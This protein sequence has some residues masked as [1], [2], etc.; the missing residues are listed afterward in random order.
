MVHDDDFYNENVLIDFSSQ[1]GSVYQP[2]ITQSKTLLP[3]SRFLAPYI[4]DNI[5]EKSSKLPTKSAIKRRLKDEPIKVVIVASSLSSKQIELITKLWD[6]IP[7]E[8]QHLNIDNYFPKESLKEEVKLGCD[9]AATLRGG[10]LIYGNPALVIDMG[11]SIISYSATDEKGNVFGSGFGLGL[12]SKLSA[13]KSFCDGE[14][15][16][17][18]NISTNSEAFLRQAIPFIESSRSVN[19]FNTNLNE[20][21]MSEIINE[22]KSKILTVIEE[23]L[24]KADAAEREQN[25]S[26][27][28]VIT[29]EHSHFLTCLLNTTTDD[30][31]M[32][33]E[34][35]YAY[36]NGV[37]DAMYRTYK[38]QDSEKKEEEISKPVEITEDSLSSWMHSQME[39]DPRL[40]EILGK[41]V[42]KEFVINKKQHKC[43][44]FLGTVVG[45]QPSYITTKGLV[46]NYRADINYL[47]DYD[48]GDCEHVSEKELRSKFKS[49][50][51]LF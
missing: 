43:Q 41:R 31:Y 47:V 45:F 16:T 38:I 30:K 36:A 2:S 8:I 23:W 4:H 42:A 1:D 18:T 44:I 13:W 17:N 12:E 21:I 46:S 6:D 48:D 15:Q 50:L 28:V 49:A 25:L 14:F 24:E 5:F 27:T 40:R 32:I 3:I 37:A 10:S 35:R 11:K 22:V 29:G 39:K 33:K 19:K 7:C 51:I 34:H 9:T 26:R 20:T